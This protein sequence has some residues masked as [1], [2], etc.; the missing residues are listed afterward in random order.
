MSNRM[1]LKTLDIG[2]TSSFGLI[3]VAA[4][5]LV[6]ANCSAQESST[7]KTAVNPAEEIIGNWDGTTLAYCGIQSYP[8][9]CNAEQK[10]QI[11][12]S[13]NDNGK[14]VGRYSCDYG[15]MNCLNVNETGKVESVAVTGKRVQIRVLMPDGLSYLFSGRV[16]N[17]E[18][19]G[20]YSAMSGGAVIERG[21]WR[22]HHAY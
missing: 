16:N 12:L 8:N 15:N 9:R 13:Q 11:T 14:I 3:V 20:G 17:G 18:I 4:M 7:Q 2:G 5:M 10:V 22:A 21:M 6:V 1:L 19:N